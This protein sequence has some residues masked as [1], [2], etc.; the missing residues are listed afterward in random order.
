MNNVNSDEV[1]EYYKPADMNA[2][3]RCL[4]KRGWLIG[5]NVVTADDLII[6][7]S[8]KGKARMRALGGVLKPHIIESLGQKSQSVSFLRTFVIRFV[9]IFKVSLGVMKVAPEVFF[10]WLKP[11]ERYAFAGLV[12]EF[13]LRDSGSVQRRA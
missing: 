5:E 4:A 9:T 11:R 6:S 13:M 7:Y 1:P 2:V 12:L 3:I 8:E 10:F